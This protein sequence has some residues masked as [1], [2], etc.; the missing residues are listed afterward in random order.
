[1]FDLYLFN[2]SGTMDYNVAVNEIKNFFDDLESHGALKLLDG[3]EIKLNIKFNHRLDVKRY[4][5][6]IAEKTGFVYW[7]ESVTAGG[8]L[9]PVIGSYFPA[10]PRYMRISEVNWCYRVALAQFDGLDEVEWLGS[11]ACRIKALNTIAFDFEYDYVIINSNFV[12]FGQ[13]YD[14]VYYFCMDLFKDHMYNN[15]ADIITNMNS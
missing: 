2:A 12:Q 8:R 7:D 15:S 3:T 5:D 9:S 1:M 13:P 11:N 14:S 4:R 10:K 6:N